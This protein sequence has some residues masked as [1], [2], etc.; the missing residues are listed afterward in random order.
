MK[1]NVGLI[2]RMIRFVIAIVFIIIGFTVS[3]WWF[4]VA[5]I[6]LFTGIFG[7]C[8]LYTLFKINTLETHE[9]RKVVKKKSPAK[10]KKSGRKK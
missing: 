3:A 10:A 2:D 6:A 5:A 4:I 1:E 7:Y 8:S 9:T